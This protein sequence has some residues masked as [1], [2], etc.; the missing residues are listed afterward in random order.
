MYPFNRI[1]MYVS[2]K[3]TLD[4]VWYVPVAADYRT[5][6]QGFGLGGYD[7]PEE[8]FPMTTAKFLFDKGDLNLSTDANPLFRVILGTQTQE[9]FK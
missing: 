1:E 4:Y 6:G 7:G 3:T 2:V 9:E 8:A 5:R